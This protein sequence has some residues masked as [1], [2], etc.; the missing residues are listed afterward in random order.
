MLIVG[1][2]GFAK[3][4]F[5]VCHK[6][7]RTENLVFFDNVST[8]LP[9]QLYGKFPSLRTEI[10]VKAHFKRTTN[11]FTLGLGNPK[12]RIELCE[13]FESW[14]GEVTSIIDPRA[15]IA[16][17]G[18]QLGSGATIL[19]H[20][21]ITGSVTTGKGLLMYPNGVLTHDC[22]LGNFVE[23]SPG[24]TILGNC[25]VGNLVHIGANAT[26]LPG[27]TLGNEVIVGA[28]AVV[29]KDIEANKT[30]RGV[31]AK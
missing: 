27:L 8:D 26:I 9:Q 13:L 30:V 25:M 11:H 22:K 10:E 14:G 7:G 12:L 6:L 29:T 5:E 15:S 28:G 18:V 4:L 24:G 3:E 23:I 17:F 16:H 31:P 20:A 1:A 21:T 19:S 2:K